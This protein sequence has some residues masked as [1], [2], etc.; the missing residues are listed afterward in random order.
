MRIIDKQHDYYDYLQDTSDP[1]VFDRRGSYVLTK[2][3]ISSYFAYIRFFRQS[4]YRFLLFQCGATFWLI[5]ATIT[6]VDSFNDVKN[7]KLELLD[8]WKN[9]NK[10]QALL[11][12]DLISFSSYFIRNYDMFI[13]EYDYDKIKSNI[14]KIRNMIEINDYRKEYT[15]CQAINKDDKVETETYRSRF[16]I[17]LLKASGLNSI[18]DPT[19]IFVAIEEYFSNKKT[20]LEKTEPVGSTNND[21]IIMHGFDTKTSFRGK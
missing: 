20:L 21:K 14:D 18:I 11:R 7:Y 2:D 8:T 10:K 1:L 19:Q 16:N 17:P 9:Y 13:S 4:K 15:I 3:D 12:L 5:L 6:E